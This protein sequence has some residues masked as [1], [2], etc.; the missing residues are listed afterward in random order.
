MAIRTQKLI[1]AV[2]IW[3]LC[4]FIL[5]LVFLYITSKGYIAVNILKTAG[6]TEGSIYTIRPERAQR[7]SKNTGYYRW[8]YSYTVNGIKYTANE[9][10][11]DN[12]RGNSRPF[13]TVYYNKNKPSDSG[14]LRINGTMLFRS[15][16]CFVASVAP[17]YLIKKY[18]N[19]KAKGLPRDI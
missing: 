12:N 1:L 7:Q 13:V 8:Y 14:I 18:N 2:R 19:G 11:F 4:A 17:I 6:I 10:R 9:R 5:G 3:S 16:I 15:F